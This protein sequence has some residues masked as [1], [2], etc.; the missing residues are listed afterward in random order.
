ME[1][2]NTLNRNHPK[3]SN[4]S[5]PMRTTYLHFLN[6][7]TT[8]ETQDYLKMT[9]LEEPQETTLE[10]LMNTQNHQDP[11]QRLIRI[12][13]HI[14]KNK[15]LTKEEYNE[16]R[17]TS[18]DFL[19]YYNNGEGKETVRKDKHVFQFANNTLK[20][21]NHYLRSEHKLLQKEIYKN[22]TLD[23]VIENTP[24]DKTQ[25]KEKLNE[26]ISYL[27]SGGNLSEDKAKVKRIA[28][29]YTAFVTSQQFKDA[30]ISKEDLR[31]LESKIKSYVS[32]IPG[33]N[34]ESTNKSTK[35]NRPKPKNLVPFKKPKKKFGSSLRKA[36]A[37]F[38]I[39]T[40]G[41]F[42]VNAHAP[43]LEETTK[44]PKQTKTNSETKKS[45][46]DF[47]ASP[48]FYNNPL[49]NRNSFTN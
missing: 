7:K 23:Q 9:V 46:S 27:D 35:I 43:N 29:Q 40:A 34:I 3:H 6:P 30:K 26:I 5:N 31:E 48:I 45:E 39:A 21:L 15:H 18:K 19:D 1:R 28:N 8:P 2:S 11:I 38:A 49:D 12:S 20:Q 25:V 41:L 16:F 22:T 13:N 47:P 42:S 37:G 44:E 17:N 24:L 14:Q 10:E 36:A 32:K 33:I 4:N